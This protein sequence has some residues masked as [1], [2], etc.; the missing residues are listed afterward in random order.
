MRVD[1]CREIA[2]RGRDTRVECA[3]VCEVPAETHARGAD[4]AVACLEPQKG[5]DGE[6][7]VFVISG[8]LLGDFPL[9]ARVGA[10]DVVGEGLWAGEFVVGGG[11]CDDV[12][13]SGDLAG[14]AGDRA[15]YWWVEISICC[16]EWVRMES[17]LLP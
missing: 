12:A 3:A 17:K 13:L 1:I 8:Q 10:G 6:L 7:G 14:E 16:V 2:H 11:G 5:G 15:G 9:V 4:A